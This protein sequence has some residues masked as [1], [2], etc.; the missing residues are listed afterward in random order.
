MR[1][2]RDRTRCI[3]L[4]ILALTQPGY[5]IQFEQARPASQ[6]PETPEQKARRAIDTKLT[7]AGWLV[8]ARRELD[9]T[10]A[11]HRRLRV[12]YEGQLR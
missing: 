12:S 6:M 9:L 1:D 2:I 10:A 5:R 3:S 7:A 4:P 8:Q 11:R